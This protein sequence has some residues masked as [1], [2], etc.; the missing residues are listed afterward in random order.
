M[1]YCGS[2]PTRTWSTVIACLPQSQRRRCWLTRCGLGRGWAGLS[3]ARP[4]RLVRL[5]VNREVDSRMGCIPSIV[6]THPS[7]F[8]LPF[9]K[10]WEQRKEAGPINLISLM[11]RYPMWH[12]A[13]A[14]GETGIP[15][16]AHGRLR[17]PGCAGL[18]GAAQSPDGDDRHFRTGKPTRSRPVH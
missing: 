8:Y 10:F 1:V 3:L 4:K 13:D 15:P 16:R 17:F 12:S 7:L 2:L 6:I 14:R 11:A 5:G 18:F 9:P